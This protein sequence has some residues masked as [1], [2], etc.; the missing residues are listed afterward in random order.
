MKRAALA[1][2]SLLALGLAATRAQATLYTY[3]TTMTAARVVDG[4]GSTSTA[5]GAGVVTVDDTLFTVTTNLTWS[6]LSGPADRSHLHFAPL[7]VSRSVAD[8]NTDFFHEVLDNPPR[9]ILGCNLVFTDCVPPS[10]TSTDVLQ[11]DASNGYGAGLA[12]GM[13]TD[14]FAGLILA[15]NAG[16]IYIDMH[17]ARYPSGEIR[18]QLAASQVAVPEPPAAWLFA[19]ALGFTVLAVAGG[20]GRIDQG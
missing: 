2:V 7:G 19:L 9:T 6:G 3:A 8:P 18:G 14:S 17:T 13:A 5:T 4:G 1:A 11:L 15:L 10:G 16:D 20:R 12:L